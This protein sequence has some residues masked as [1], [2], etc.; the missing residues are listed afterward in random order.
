MAGAPTPHH[1]TASPQAV[2][3]PAQSPLVQQLQQVRDLAAAVLDSVAF[4]LLGEADAMAVLGTVEDL[5]RRVDAARVAAAADMSVRSRR[6]LG[7]ESLAYKNGATN[8]IDLITRLT[9]VSSREANRR[10]RL[11]ENVTARLAGTSMLPPYYPAVA[12]ALTAGDLGVDAAENI[13]TALDRVA[14]RVAPDDL[15]TAERAL[16]AG[17]TGAITD[18]TRGLPGEGFAFPADL[19]RGMAGQWQARLDPDGTAPTEPV[20]EAR[21]TVGF[22]LFR[23]GL[24][25]LRGGVTPELRGIMNAIFDTY[26]SAHAAPAFPT[27]EEQALMDSGQLIPGAEAAALGDDRT[28]GEK[29]ADILRGVFEAATRDTGT[30]SMGGAAPTVM[31]HV[32]QADLTAGRGVGWIDGVEAPVSLTTVKQALCTGGFQEIRFGQNNKV[33]SLSTENRFFNRAQRRA[34]AARD[35]GCTI[36]GCTVPPAWCEVHHVTPWHRG[37]KTDI[38]NGVLLC[39][40]HHHSIDTSGWEIRMIRGKPQ[41]RAPY[42]YDPTRTWRA[43][44][45]NRAGGRALHGVARSGSR[46]ARPTST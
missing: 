37:G 6:I 16:V 21:S 19:V 25:P 2:L 11:G 7:H 20:A 22:G 9:R 12:V 30:P 34:I 8:G 29:R 10:V 4:S 13:V 40:Y 41:V 38:D 33:L 36:P 44:G 31:I 43:A 3:S 1:R 24:Y 28:S 35:G 46:Q 14:A 17:A 39:W 5:G 18:E 32:N 42:C 26:L 27:A 23:D 45:E 15:G